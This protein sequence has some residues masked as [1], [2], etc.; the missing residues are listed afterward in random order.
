MNLAR[1]GR[2]GCLA[3]TSVDGC[4]LYIIIHNFYI[5]CDL[6]LRVGMLIWQVG[7]K[8][9]SNRISQ[10]PTGKI[11]PKAEMYIPGWVNSF[12]KVLVSSDGCMLKGVNCKELLRR[13]WYTWCT[14]MDGRVARCWSSVSLWLCPMCCQMRK[15]RA[16]TLIAHRFAIS[17]ETLTFKM[18]VSYLGG[19]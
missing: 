10:L 7:T 6:I 11:E 14:G 3:F 2:L 19:R 17:N 13:C 16:V 4:I 9:N 1:S 5:A 15:C 8:R 12:Q 18:G